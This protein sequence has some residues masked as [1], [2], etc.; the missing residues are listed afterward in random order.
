M[1]NFAQVTSQIANAN[2]D[3]LERYI[4]A[5]WGMSHKLFK[6]LETGPRPSGLPWNDF[7]TEERLYFRE[8]ISA[9]LHDLLREA[10]AISALPADWDV[11][12]GTRPSQKRRVVA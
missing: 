10:E 9:V 12:H 11:I 1:D 4:G 3:S 7:S 2:P 6:K 5:L 8:A